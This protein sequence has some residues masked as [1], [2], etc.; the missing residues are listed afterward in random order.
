MRDDVWLYREQTLSG[1]LRV[2]H[3]LPSS[4]SA[5][6]HCWVSWVAQWSDDAAITASIPESC[7]WA[8]GGGGGRAVAI[9]LSFLFYFSLTF[10]STFST[11]PLG[12]WGYRLQLSQLL[13]CLHLPFWTC[14]DF[15]FPF[16]N[17]TLLL[18]THCHQNQF[19]QTNRLIISAAEMRLKLLP[20]KQI[21]TRWMKP[22]NK[23]LK[24]TTRMIN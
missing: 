9:Y 3:M 23:T 5:M 20:M 24:I 6:G 22:A 19:V 2:G 7:G 11:F 12:N 16:G 8:K 17:H 21:K 4:T 10:F 14:I 13:C 18:S 15:S 1:I